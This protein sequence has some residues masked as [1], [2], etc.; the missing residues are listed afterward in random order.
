[1]VSW[2]MYSCTKFKSV[3]V[4]CSEWVLTIV[5]Y[6]ISS[7]FCISARCISSCFLPFFSL[8]I[9]QDNFHIKD[10]LSFWQTQFYWC[11]EE[12]IFTF[13]LNF[14]WM[15]GPN[16]ENQGSVQCWTEK[17]FCKKK[18]KKHQKFHHPL[19]NSFSK[20]FASK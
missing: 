9:N 12:E 14:C 4:Y 8:T 17:A 15:L 16:L 20:C 2:T 7:M 19:F 11:K 13:G 5:L 6:W 3:I 10:Y 1:M 18:K